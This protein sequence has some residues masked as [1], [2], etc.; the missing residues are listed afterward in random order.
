[1]DLIDVIPRLQ[2]YGGRLNILGLIWLAGLTFF[3][4]QTIRKP[5]VELRLISGKRKPHWI[6][7]MIMSC[8]LVLLLH[9][10]T[11]ELLTCLVIAAGDFPDA[12]LE[13]L[14]AM[15]NDVYLSIVAYSLTLFHYDL[16][17]FFRVN[18]I[19][20]LAFSCLFLINVGAAMMHV[21]DYSTFEGF[22]RQWR[23]WLLYPS[24]KGLM[25]LGYV[26]MLVR[27]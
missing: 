23:F 20:V 15:K 12:S 26:S 11:D 18:W 13:R 22:E 6:A 4:F 21:G 25:A 7:I 16:Q 2:L 3:T 27:E 9:F 17:R 1:M 19:T 14:W 5:F 24:T 8:C 10:L